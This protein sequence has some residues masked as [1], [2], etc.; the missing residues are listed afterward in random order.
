MPWEVKKNGSQYCVYKKGAS[1]PIKGGCHGTKK[2]ATQHMKA[3]Y[4]NVEGVQASQDI[5]VTKDPVGLW[6]VHNVPLISTGIEYPLQSGPTTF[7]ESQL[8]DAV[9]ALEDPAVVEPRIKL[10]HTAKYNEALIGDAEMAFGRI[11]ASTMRLSDNGQTI[12]GDYLV[13][14]W[15][16]TV[17][18]IALPNRSIEGN[19]DVETVTGKSYELVITAVSLLG[20]YWP[21]CQVLED[22]PLWYGG[23]IPEGVEFDEAIASQLA[24]QEVAASGGRMPKNKVQADADTT[25][26]RR[27]FYDRAMSGELEGLP[28]GANPYRWWI[29]AERIGNDGNLYLIVEDDEDGDLYKFSVAINDEEVTFSDPTAVKVEYTERT[30]AARA[31]VVAGMMVAD[32]AV[33]MHAS[34]ADTG[35]PAKS[36]QEGAARMTNDERRKALAAALGLPENAPWDKIRAASEEAARQGVEGGEPDNAGLRG[37]E[38]TP[39]QQPPAHQT[40]PGTAPTGTGNVGTEEQEQEEVERAT[41]NQPDADAQAGTVTVDKA[42]WEATQRGAQLAAKHEDER[43][44]TRRSNKVEAAI[45]AGK[46]PPA[47][48]EHYM[49]LMAM[50]EQGTTETL[51]SLQASAV[52]LGRGLGASGDG[53]GE[54]VAASSGAGFP[55]DWFPEIAERRNAAT[56]GAAPV[57]A[58]SQEG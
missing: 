36:T 42:T 56:A 19:F 48:K 15:L 58:R 46:I 24:A 41:Q 51:D 8:A 16:G 55:D 31:A 37:D 40:P 50:D 35:G 5:E 18:S 45:K 47:R 14:E 54:G 6:R 3:L 20:V 53:D 9:E 17:M 33:V 39:D 30:A 52:P 44:A 57:V 7:T 27:Q 32:P 12:Y 21:G 4:T 25:R 43:V 34:R 10:G 22:L 26:I 2:A 28:D 11:D 29:R 49:K 1:S 38:V 13:P 23:D